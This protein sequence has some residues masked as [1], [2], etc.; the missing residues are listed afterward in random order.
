MSDTWPITT[1][2]VQSY[3]G[4][5][6]D[7][8]RIQDAVDAT[9]VYVEGRR[10]DLDLASGTAPADVW[11][12]SVIYASIVYNQRSSPSGMAAF[13]DAAAIDI[14]GDPAYPRA[15]RMI[16]WRRPIAL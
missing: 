14:S 9:I 2:D 10:S 16:G 15:M 3:L 1:D 5:L 8:G 7:P 12:G 11:L 4:P 13:G 6:A